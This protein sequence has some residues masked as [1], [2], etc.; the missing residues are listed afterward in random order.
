M[1]LV[2]CVIMLGYNCKLILFSDIFNDLTSFPCLDDSVG[3]DQYIKS[4]IRIITQ[5]SRSD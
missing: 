1:K 3:S 2:R 4:S 5:K